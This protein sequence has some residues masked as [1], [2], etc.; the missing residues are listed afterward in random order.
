MRGYLSQRGQ[1]DALP[2]APELIAAFIVS[3]ARPDPGPGRPARA[4]ATIERRL[5]AVS[6]AHRDAGLPDPGTDP[7]VDETLRGVRRQCGIA[8][9]PKEN[10]Q[11]E[12]LDHML[13]AIPA[14]THDGRRDRALLLLGLAGALRRSELVAIDIEH[15][16]REAEGMILTI[17][18]LQGR[19]VRCR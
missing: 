13:R 9:T 2:I 10:L 19:P 3:E 18:P 6:A 11:L 15:I 16:R 14:T 1:P 12:H 7:L 8:R 17:P 5:A 4:I